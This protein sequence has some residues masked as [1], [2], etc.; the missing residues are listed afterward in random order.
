MNLG[1]N[2]EWFMSS[3][4]AIFNDNSDKFNVNPIDKVE[5]IQP[6]KFLEQESQEIVDNPS[7]NNTINHAVQRQMACM[8]ND[9]Q[10]AKILVLKRGSV[11]IHGI[12]DKI[13][14]FDL[15]EWLKEIKKRA[16]ST[17]NLIGEERR[18]IRR[19]KAWRE[20]R[21]KFALLLIIH[22]KS[23]LSIQPIIQA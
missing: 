4:N 5:P 21:R 9:Y 22:A 10:V 19:E 13:T 12:E 20:A 3:E 11:K 17:E 16:D 2:K 8:K 23:N 14:Y 1:F 15:K 18:K 7:L 6:K